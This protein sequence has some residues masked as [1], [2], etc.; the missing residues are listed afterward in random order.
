MTANQFGQRRLL[1]IGIPLYR[2]ASPI[3]Q[4]EILTGPRYMPQPI[5]A[6]RPCD[7]VAV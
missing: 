5:D 7:R 2:E 1:T 6:F 4:Q 3:G